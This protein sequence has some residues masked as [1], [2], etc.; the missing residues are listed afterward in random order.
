M[1]YL[2]AGILAFVAMT[3]YAKS[4]K[5]GVSENSF[6]TIN[7][8][9]PLEPGVSWF[10]T[11]GNHIPDSDND[12]YNLD[13]YDGDIEFVPMCWSQHYSA[14]NIRNYCK[15]H[16]EVK[17]LLGFNEPN[18][19]SQANMTPQEAAEAWP[20]VQALAKELNLQLVA[21]VL[22]YSPD[23][24]YTNPLTWMDE[25]VALVGKDAF[26]FTAIHNYGGLGVM[27]DLATN[28]H[29]RYGKDV[30]VTEFCFWPN[31]GNNNST[32]TP[33]NQ[34]K[35]MVETLEWLETTDWIFRYAWFKAIGNYDKPTGPNYGLLKQSGTDY[36][37]EWELTPQGQVYV[38]MS[39]YDTGVWNE[40][41]TVVP[42]SE[43]VKSSNIGYGVTNDDQCPG[44][45]E[46]NKFNSGA[47]ATWQ[48]DIKH[49]GEHEV[50]LRL[51]G[52][53]EPTR[54]DPLLQWVLVNTGTRSDTNGETEIPLGDTFS[55]ALPNSDTEYIEYTSALILPEGH[56]Q[57]R[58]KDMRSGRPSGIKI[59]TISVSEAAAVNSIISDSDI[60]DGAIYNLHGICVSRDAN[61]F[62]SL[63]AGIYIANGKKIVLK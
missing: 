4:D 55:P 58:L 39:S 5:R 3:G 1:R 28:F 2:L 27:V 41:N 62:R 11:W 46:I 57:L 32:V 44:V 52:F 13:K 31:T 14:D 37:G 33:D 30:W 6:M 22:N 21:P 63:P 54:Y 51:S 40:L 18:F 53:G 12:F 10:Y 29:D 9:S 24:P 61:S 59:S 47:T 49:T 23:A 60:E 34:I 19:K 35:S 56:V 7:Q 15:K 48:F 16:P 42:A 8:I 17:Y 25:F 20:E 45:L 36:F 43:V 26:D 50:K 38:H